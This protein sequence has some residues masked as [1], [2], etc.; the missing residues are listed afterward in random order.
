MNRTLALAAIAFTLHAPAQTIKP[1]P[2]NLGVPMPK[3]ATVQPTLYCQL[4]LHSGWAPCPSQNSFTAPENSKFTNIT[5]ADFVLAKTLQISPSLTIYAENDT[6]A[7]SKPAAICDLNDQGDVTKCTLGEGHTLTEVVST[8]YKA[9]REENVRLQNENQDTVRRLIKVVAL[10]TNF[11]ESD[12]KRWDEFGA[13]LKSRTDKP[14]DRK[15][16]K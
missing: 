12:R 13:T 9:Q 1:K 16:A 2:V 5:N 10:C 7:G 3:L 8:I 6:A 11:I 15:K 4:S 14:A